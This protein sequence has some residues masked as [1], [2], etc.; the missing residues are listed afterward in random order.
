MDYNIQSDNTWHCTFD[1]AQ[2]RALC[3]LNPLPTNDTY[4]YHDFPC[5]PQAHN[6]L[7]WRF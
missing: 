3:L 2:C 5:F 7:L 6:K 1:L 4:M